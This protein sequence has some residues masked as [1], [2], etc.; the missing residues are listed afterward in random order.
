MCGSTGA[1]SRS[2]VPGQTAQPAQ[3]TPCSTPP[4]NSTCMPTQMPRTGRPSSIRRAMSLSP[5]TERKAGHAGGERA[6]AGDDEAVAV[7]GGVRIGG[8]GDVGA[9]PGEGPLGRAEVP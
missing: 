2:T 3:A 4:A 7:E 8:H 6:D 9:D 5:P 1:S